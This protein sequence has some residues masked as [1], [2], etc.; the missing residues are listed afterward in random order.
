MLETLSE[1]K[2]GVLPVVGI[3]ALQVFKPHRVFE[4]WDPTNEP[5]HLFEGHAYFVDKQ[6]Y[7]FLELC[8]DPDEIMAIVVNQSDNP[9]PRELLGVFLGRGVTATSPSHPAAAPIAFQRLGVQPSSDSKEPYR[10]MC[11]S[12]PLLARVDKHMRSRW[13]SKEALNAFDLSEPILRHLTKREGS[14]NGD[15]LALRIPGA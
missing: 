7:M 6:I 15:D 5:P 2:R 1:T 3:N 12:S 11:Q 14:M 4:K 9:P 13:I 8:E 10:E